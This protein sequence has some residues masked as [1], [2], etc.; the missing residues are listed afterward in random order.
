[1]ASALYN[2]ARKSFLD[3]GL[4]WGSDDIRAL[5][6]QSTYTFSA[7]HEFVADVVAA[8][9]GATDYARKATTGRAVGTGAPTYALC[10]NITWAGL[11]GAVNQTIGGLIFF[12][13]TGSD[14]TARL[15]A[16]CDNPDLTTENQDVVANFGSQRVFSW[17]G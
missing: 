7:A 5:L 3:K 1:M 8:E 16:F 14:A 11:G 4:A 12:L 15:I 2:G 10:D 13:N 17:S 6:V 9:L